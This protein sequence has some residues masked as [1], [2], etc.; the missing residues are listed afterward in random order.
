MA[1][2]SHLR[3]CPHACAGEH[4]YAERA[5]KQRGQDIAGELAQRSGAGAL[6]AFSGILLRFSKVITL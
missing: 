3:V 5:G 4:K 6:Q 1:T 2:R